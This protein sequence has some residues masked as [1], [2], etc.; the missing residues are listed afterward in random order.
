MH[1]KKIFGG[2]IFER[3]KNISLRAHQLE[4]FLVDADVVAGVAPPRVHLAARRV[5][6]LLADAEVPH[7]QLAQALVQ[8]RVV[9]DLEHG[10]RLHDHHQH[11]E[12]EEN[13]DNELLGFWRR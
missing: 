4:A 11:E 8:R 9:A 13:A 3:P 2:V 10:A 7:R 5:P 1:R 6:A 12:D